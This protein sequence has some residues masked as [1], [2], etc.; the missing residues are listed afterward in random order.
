MFAMTTQAT[1]N[2]WAAIDVVVTAAYLTYVVRYV[3]R[4]NKTESL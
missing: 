1:L 2:M 4:A 3:R